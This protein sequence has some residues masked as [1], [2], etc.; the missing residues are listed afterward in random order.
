MIKKSKRNIAPPRPNC[1]TEQT[2]QH[3][4]KGFFLVRLTQN[5]LNLKL[6]IEIQT[7]STEIRCSK[8]KIHIY[9]LNSFFVFYSGND[10]WTQNDPF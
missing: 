9:T 10:F 1:G 6:D 4:T 8:T 2:K 7:W 3:F 5:S